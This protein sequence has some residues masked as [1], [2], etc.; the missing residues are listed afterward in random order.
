MH[1]LV[2]KHAGWKGRCKRYPKVARTCVGP[3]GIKSKGLTRWKVIANPNRGTR[4]PGTLKGGMA[5]TVITWASANEHWL[6]KGN[7]GRL[8]GTGKLSFTVRGPDKVKKMSKVMIFGRIKSILLQEIVQTET[9]ASSGKKIIE[10]NGGSSFPVISLGTAHPGGY[11]RTAECTPGT[12]FIRSAP[13]GLSHRIRRGVHGSIKVSQ[14][15]VGLRIYY[16]GEPFAQGSNNVMPK[17]FIKNC[18]VNKIAKELRLLFSSVCTQENPQ[19]Q[20]TTSSQDSFSQRVS[21]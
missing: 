19:H 8:Q 6:R 2:P 14:H 20:P 7:S 10:G 13:G 11:S 17:G 18:D 12:A 16:E 5:Y 4:W 15:A 9:T 1:R 3:K 21:M